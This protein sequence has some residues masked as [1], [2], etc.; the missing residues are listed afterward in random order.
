M[1]IECKDMELV[2]EL[3]IWFNEHRRDLPWRRTYDPYHVWI[4]EIMLQQTQMER[5]VEYF[6][7]WMK[8]FPDIRSLADASEQEVLKAWEGLGYYSRARNIVKAAGL[9]VEQHGGLLPDEYDR[10]LAL[11]GIGPYTAGAIMSIAFER[12]CPVIDANV[13]RLFARLGDVAMPMKEKAVHGT[14]REILENMLRNVS[15]RDFNQGL[16]ELGALIC[17]PKNPDCADC[18][19]RQHC[20]ALVAGTI[21]ERPVKKKK[22]QTIDIIM[23]CAIIEHEGKLFI[24]QRRDDDVWGGLW[25]FPGG[26]LKNGESAAQAA[27][28]E[29]Y[30]ETEL[31]AVNL[32]PFRTVTHHYTRYRVTLHSFFCNTSKVPEPRLHAATAFRWVAL[33]ELDQY[34]FPSGHRQ[35][36]AHMRQ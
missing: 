1:E 32:D 33:D 25:E 22:P 18:P 10:L 16:M 12:P 31:R 17:T 36:I 5:G 28:R 30:E 35:L 20:R 23:A 29:L 14:L 26:R 27:V 2:Q 19:V 21:D 3:L 4:S 6:N 9:I 8:R 24:Q 13:E 7:R 34:P 11:P 15:P